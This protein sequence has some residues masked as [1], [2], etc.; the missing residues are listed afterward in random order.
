MVVILLLIYGALGALFWRWLQLSHPGASMRGWV[1]FDLE[2]WILQNSS[3]VNIWQKDWLR[4]WCI[5]YLTRI[6]LVL[7]S[8]SKIAA[9]F[10][11]GN[12]KELPAIPDHLSA[13]GRDF[14]LQCLQ[15]NPLNRPTASQ[16]LEHP[17]VK[18]AAPL[19]RPILSA[20]P[21]EGPP[22]TTNAVRSQVLPL[23]LCIR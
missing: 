2:A 21:S 23:S 16:L 7:C 18:N 8:S 13:E 1:N 20:E 10:K 22:S 17:F 3:H 19:E 15:R 5:W 14:V 12:S 4:A 6:F 11:I 9:M